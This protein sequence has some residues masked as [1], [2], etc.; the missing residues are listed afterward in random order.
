MGVTT[1][2]EPNVYDVR[3][4][5]RTVKYEELMKKLADGDISEQE[6]NERIEEVEDEELAQRLKNDIMKAKSKKLEDTEESYI[7]GDISDEELERRMDELFESGDEFLEYE[8]EEES[9]GSRVLSRAKRY[10]LPICVAVPF[11]FVV[12]MPGINP[13]MAIV[14]APILLLLGVVVYVGLMDATGELH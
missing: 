13:M 5:I 9:E 14:A 4:V 3:D 11:L 10:A 6:F 8:G 1:E 2:Y 7:N 12:L